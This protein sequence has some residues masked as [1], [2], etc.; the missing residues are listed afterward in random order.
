MKI[1]LISACALALSLAAAQTVQPLAGILDRQGN[2]AN[3]QQVN[4]LRS[5]KLQHDFSDETAEQRATRRQRAEAVKKGFQYAWAGY[6]KYAYG[7]DEIDVLKM[8]PKTTRNGWGATLVDALDTLWVLGMKDEFARARDHVANINF[9]SDGGQLAKVF[10]TNIRYVGGLLSA[11]ELSKDRVFLHKAVELTDLLMPAFDTPLGLPWQMLNITTGQGSSETPGTTST[12]LA[13][14]GTFQMEFYRLSQLTGNATYH[15]AAQ[16]AIT[17]MLENNSPQDASSLYT[18]PGLYPLDFD[19]MSGRFTNSAAYWGGGGDSF[20]EYLIKTWILSDFMLHRNLDMWRESI[21]A[22]SN[23][24]VAESTDGFLFPGFVDGTKFFPYVDTFTN[25]IPGTLGI[26]SKL[27]G[28]A[29][30]FSLAEQLL[31]AGY[32]VFAKMPS[33]LGAEAVRFV[34]R[35]VGSDYLQLSAQERAQVDRYGIVLERP[36]YVL[37]P[38]LIESLFVMYRLT[39]KQEY[40]DRVWDIW[41][42]IQRNCRVPNGYVGTANVAADASSTGILNTVDST[43]SFFFAETLKYVYLTFADHD[44]ISLDS[45]VFTTEAHPLSRDLPH[46]KI[47]GAKALVLDR[48]L[49]GALSAVVE[50][51]VLKE[52]GVEKI[53]LLETGVG[54]APVQG[55]VYLVQGQVGKLRAVAAQVRA[56]SGIEQAVQVV[57]RRTLLSERVLEEEGVL[58]DVRLGEFRLDAVPLAEDVVSLEQPGLFKALYVDGDFSGIAGIARGLMRLQGLWG[59]FPRLV[60]KG[61]YAQVLAQSLKRLRAE[62]TGGAGAMSSMFDAAVL[63]DRAA[64]LTT[65]LLTQLTYEGLLSE[66]FGIAGGAVATG[67]G[68][69]SRVSVRGDD[70]VYTAIRDAGFADVGAALSAMTQQLQT[71]YESRHSAR[72]VQEIRRF[73]G[74]LGGLQA[75]H[76]ALKAHVALAEAV[77]KRTQTDDF[78]ATLEI[79]QTLVGGDDLHAGQRAHIERM[80]ALGDPHAHVPGVSS[81]RQA[82]APAPAAAPNSLHKILRLLCLCALWRGAALKQ[83]QYD[84]WYDEITAAFGHHHAIT[85]ANLA[86]AGLLAP[87]ARSSGAASAPA[88][89]P[90]SGLGFVRRALNLVVADDADDVAYA[91]AGYVPLLVRLVQVLAQ[92]PAVHSPASSRYAALLRPLERTRSS[93][94]TQQPGGGVRGGWAGWED[95][96]AAVPGASFDEPQAP[97]SALGRSERALGEKPPATL[98]VF[99]GGCTS[100]EISALRRLSQL[101]GHRYVVATTEVL[102]GNA[103]LD[104]LIHHK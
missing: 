99:V 87:P 75:E 20:Y 53:F 55:V 69:R 89:A 94:E 48:D 60:G 36:Y 17:S 63:L 83:K 54:D 100:A 37:R 97:P 70:A 101:H 9:R 6:E 3:M 30:Y 43:E 2:R 10:E 102:N 14:I 80:L 21:Q 57:P 61:D 76:Q 8:R 29:T 13:E 74:R 90:A 47:R 42:G 4:T 46:G 92:D 58:G 56:L 32:S 84:A 65:P 71:T 24:A 16:R 77:Q 62:A 38:E 35:N 103:L 27:A 72:T 25:F 91:Y 31:E 45:Y 78:A 26:A 33:S 104:P 41:Q 23:Y 52:H 19:M 82:P 15:E 85:L 12:N 40:A 64:D 95:V 51:A 22:F 39:G 28:S 5:Q 59:F 96:L 1:Q 98:V 34:R 49:S 86:R 18:I 81:E 93:R 88:P 73:V 7:A 68:G 50:F 11:Y 44:V 67:E 66:V 79:E